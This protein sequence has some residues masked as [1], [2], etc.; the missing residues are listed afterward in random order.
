MSSL[1]PSGYNDTV[2]FWLTNL[3]A[4]ASGTVVFSTNGTAWSTNS[5]ANG[6]ATSAGDAAA[7]PHCLLHRLCRTMITCVAGG[8]QMQVGEMTQALR[9]QYLGLLEAF[10]GREG[11]SVLQGLDAL[12][13]RITRGLFSRGVGEVDAIVG[14]HRLCLGDAEGGHRQYSGDDGGGGVLPESLHRR[15][16][17]WTK[18]R[19]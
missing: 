1:T 13:Q 15:L 5:V 19:A 18:P 2:S 6:G 4:G 16:P 17:A 11:G 12:A 7:Q 10:H 14:M 9:F 3:P 8:L